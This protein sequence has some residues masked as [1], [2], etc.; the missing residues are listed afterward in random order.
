MYTNTMAWEFNSKLAARMDVSFAFSPFDN[1]PGAN[2]QNGRVFLRNAEV[3]YQ[4]SENVRLH[5]QV[6]QN[7]YGYHMSPYGYYSPYGRAAFS[8]HDGLVRGGLR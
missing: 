1:T 5:L 8:S 7:P 3:L 6:Q 4:P 2:G